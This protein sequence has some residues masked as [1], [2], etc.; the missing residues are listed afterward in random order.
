MFDM[1]KC[2]NADMFYTWPSEIHMYNTTAIINFTPWGLQLSW[3]HVPRLSTV[4]IFIYMFWSSRKTTLT[5]STIF[6]VHNASF[7]RGMTF[8]YTFKGIWPFQ[9]KI[10]YG[11]GKMHIGYLNSTFNIK[12]NPAANRLSLIC[13]SEILLLW[14]VK[15]MV[16]MLVK[17]KSWLDWKGQAN[18][19]I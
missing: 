2:T 3:Y 8:S 12:I 14:S 19:C 4:Q 7:T 5:I 10:N 15:G 1:W 6:I 11:V 18:A 13:V 17:H 16:L 9:D